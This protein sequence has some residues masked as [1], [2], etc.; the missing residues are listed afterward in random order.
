MEFFL[1]EWPE[2]IVRWAHVI[3]A[4][5]WIGSSFFFNW[6]ESHLEAPDPPRQG[7]AGELWMVHGGGF[8]R[9]EKYEAAPAALPRTLHWFFLEATFTWISGALLLVLVYYTA[10]DVFLVAPG[11]STVEPGTAI[12]IGVGAIALGWVVYDLLWRSPLARHAALSAGLFF[13]FTLAVAWGLAQVLAGRAT[14]MHTG[15]MLGTIMAANVW[16]HIIPAQRRMVAAMREGKPV[17]V[18]RNRAAGLRSLHNNYMTLPVVFTMISGHYPETYGHAHGWLV[19]AALGAIGIAVRHA[20]NLRNRG[21][22]RGA[23]GYGA[24][25]TVAML[26]LMGAL[27]PR[28]GEEA[29]AAS[30]DA[31]PFAAARAVIEH[32]CQTCHSARPR[33]KDF[34]EPPEGVAFD[35][36]AQIKAR[37]PRILAR[38][39]IT[40][41]MPLGDAGDMT[42]EERALLGHWIRQGAR[43]E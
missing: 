13:A 14:Y 30:A 21:Q 4:I 27:A 42:D 9:A 12:A 35:T 8:Y 33:H 2:L 23:L 24:A 6:E 32:R 38:A 37:A 40:R 5:A 3:F 17:D 16:V 43:I 20:F 1:G 41:T 18:A 22:W 7:V 25:A 15:A 34:K 28:A 10:A 26:A 36:P 19:L 31:V 39:V 11:G 29:Q